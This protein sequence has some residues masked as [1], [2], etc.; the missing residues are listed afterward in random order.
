MRK[1]K[2]HGM[3]KAGDWDSKRVRTLREIRNGMGSIREGQ[4]GTLGNFTRN[5]HIGF[6][7]DACPD[8]GACFFVSGLHYDDFE[9]INTS[10]YTK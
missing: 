2:Y 5:G 1:G 6:E 4:E 3:K 9:L 7:A 10:E 8:C